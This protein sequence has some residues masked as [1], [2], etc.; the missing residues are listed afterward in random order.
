MPEKPSP[1]IG[2]IQAR[3]KLDPLRL[4]KKADEL[5]DPGSDPR[6]N[7]LVGLKN[8]CMLCPKDK[9]GVGFGSG[10]AIQQEA[11]SGYNSRQGS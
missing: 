8:H 1:R 6:L 10:F 5:L 7:A 4:E 9:Q 3:V 11:G 2:R